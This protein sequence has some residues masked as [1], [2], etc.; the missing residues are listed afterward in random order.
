MRVYESTPVVWRKSS[1]SF[2][3]NECVEVATQG[4]VV[5]LRDSKLAPDA[6]MLLTPAATW[7][8][9][10]AEVKNRRFDH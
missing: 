4:A 3:G 8:G 9:F 1:R 2:A 7:R 6:P 5:W 10:V